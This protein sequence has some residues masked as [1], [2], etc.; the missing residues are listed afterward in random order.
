MRKDRLAL[1]VRLAVKQAP[2]IDHA[3]NYV[4]VRAREDKGG[5]NRAIR[6]HLFVHGDGD[7]DGLTN[8]PL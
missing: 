4:F 3:W 8:Q 1:Y 5:G 7:V 6:V 2:I